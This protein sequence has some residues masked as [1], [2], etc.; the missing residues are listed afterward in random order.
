M[1]SFATLALLGGVCASAQWANLAN[2]DDIR[3]NNHLD[4]VTQAKFYKMLAK[5]DDYV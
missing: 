5:N 2:M 1:S 4:G 3:L